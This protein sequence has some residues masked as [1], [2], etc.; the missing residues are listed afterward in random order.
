MQ[1]CLFI[2]QQYDR[3]LKSGNCDEVGALKVANF[4]FTCDKTKR[5]SDLFTFITKQKE[6]TWTCCAVYQLTGRQVL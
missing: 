5:V 3:H 4:D 1:A 6:E 2:K